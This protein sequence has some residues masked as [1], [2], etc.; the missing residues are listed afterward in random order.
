[1]RPRLAGVPGYPGP[2]LDRLAEVRVAFDAQL[3]GSP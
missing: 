1:M 3:V 2:V